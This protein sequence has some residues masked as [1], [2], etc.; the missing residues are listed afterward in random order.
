MRTS[1]RARRGPAARGALLALALLAGV[2]AP[3]R[4][5]SARELVVSA[6][7]SLTAAFA[8]IATA[9]EKSA[10]GVTVRTNFAGSSTLVRQI[11]EGAPVD[12]VA[13]ADEANMEKLVAAGAVKGRPEIFAR[14]RLTI[15]VQ[16]GNP[17]G[18]TGVADL[19]RPD[20][21][22]ALCAPQVPAGR[23]AREVFAR[24]GVTVPETSQELDVKAVV[25]RVA[26]GE[27]DAGIV[28][29]TDVR[30]A[31]DAV[32][33]VAIPSAQNVIARYPVAVLRDAKH[34]EEARA[35]LRF[36][37]G[38]QAQAILARHGFLPP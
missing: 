30:A 8:E 5:A 25:T 6:A 37:L 29:V 35:L 11:L 3:V 23:Y 36:L 33:D 9:F 21:T 27:A 24:A 1:K 17:K 15:L 38:E 14:N 10:P 31:G 34:P 22:L 28:Y 19:A 2:L 18:I 20:V 12:V 7:A 26:L 32:A 13:S 16:R 4:P